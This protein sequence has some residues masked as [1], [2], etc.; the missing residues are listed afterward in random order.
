MRSPLMAALAAGLLLSASPVAAQ[1]VHKGL[2]AGA[3]LG[4]GSARLSCQ[5]CLGHRAGG[6]SGYVRAGATITRQMLVGLEANAWTHNEND[7]DHLMT[8]LQGI[9][10][11]YPDP[12]SGL[13]IKT[14]LG[15]SQYSAKD[16][17]DKISSQ[18][19]SASIGF[20]YEIGV[21]KSMSIVPYANFIGS[22][23]AD[24][25]LNDNIAGLGANSSL[26]QLGIGLTLH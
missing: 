26:F 20:G 2:W 16:D 3:G 6:T 13:Y 15:V 9:F 12:R 24:V 23:G 1:A 22:A 5:I 11:L 25:R 17:E 7:V 18:A 4:V 8:S 10:M 14:G 19:L 21:S